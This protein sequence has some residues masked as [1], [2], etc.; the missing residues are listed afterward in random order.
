MMRSV[1]LLPSRRPPSNSCTSTGELTEIQPDCGDASRATIGTLSDAVTPASIVTVCVTV[2]ASLAGL[3]AM[4]VP[5]GLDAAGLPL[6]LQIIGRPLDEQGV[7]NAGLAIE[8]RAGF[9]ADEGVVFPDHFDH[10]WRAGSRERVARAL[11]ALQPGVTEIHIQPAADTPEVRALTDHAEQWIDDLA[12]ATDGSL[13]AAIEASAA[14]SH[15]PLSQI[16]WF[17]PHQA[18]QRILDGTAKRLG[19]DASR[20]I[21]TVACHGNTS[22]ASVP[23]ALVTAIRDGRIKRGNLVLLEAM[24]GGFTWGAA[25]LR[26]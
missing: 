17:V 25:L 7:L 19:I 11:D 9:T 1:W 18:N 2:P 3:P 15:I 12:F 14:A 22:A 10:D 20:V 26:W 6:G 16:D 21:S 24:G 5:G 13:A 8:Q 4:S 23:L